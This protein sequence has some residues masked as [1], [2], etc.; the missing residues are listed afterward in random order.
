MYVCM[1]VSMCVLSVCTV[2]VF[3]CM[4]VYVAACLPVCVVLR[5]GLLS[6]ERQTDVLRE[7]ETL[8]MLAVSLIKGAS[9]GCPHFRSSR[10][11]S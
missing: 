5:T 7:S 11:L 2:C 4:T 3:V 10:V 9:H 8:R 1:Y 6:Q